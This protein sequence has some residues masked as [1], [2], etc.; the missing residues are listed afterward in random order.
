M[1]AAAVAP[2]A[3]ASLLLLTAGA[4]GLDVLFQDVYLGDVPL[5]RRW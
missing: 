4:L 3:V 5:A 1:M 2:P